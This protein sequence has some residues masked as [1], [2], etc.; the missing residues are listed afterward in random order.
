[1]LSS[2]RAGDCIHHFSFH[3][4]APSS[5]SS[6]PLQTNFRVPLGK[7]TPLH[8]RRAFT[9]IVDEVSSFRFVHFR[10]ILRCCSWLRFKSTRLHWNQH[11]NVS[12]TGLLRGSTCK[13]Y[14]DCA[15]RRG[16][17]LWRWTHLHILW[18]GLGNKSTLGSLEKDCDFS[19]V[20]SH[21]NKDQDCGVNPDRS[22][23]GSLQ[24]CSWLCEACHDH[25]GN[26]NTILLVCHL[27]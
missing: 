6:S 27:Y 20:L 12:V 9:N 4:Q 14:R 22:N 8:T 21:L 2:Q 7:S 5:D 24:P 13:C 15:G 11:F 17:G 23:N 10:G 1:M 25:H 19:H 16:A 26:A 18:L 3:Y